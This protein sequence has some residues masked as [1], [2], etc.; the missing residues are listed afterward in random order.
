MLAWQ[1]REVLNILF[2][3]TGTM[4]P[5]TNTK[6]W[7]QIMAMTKITHDESDS[8]RKDKEML[9]MASLCGPY[10]KWESLAGV[11]VHEN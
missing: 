4:E 3:G 1:V 11:N 5:T 2:S 7:V 8:Q 9:T 10:G 6:Y